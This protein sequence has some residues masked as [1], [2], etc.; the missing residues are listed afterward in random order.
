MERGQIV[1]RYRIKGISRRTKTTDLCSR[2]LTLAIN[3]WPHFIDIDLYMYIGYTE[4]TSKES[5]LMEK[6]LYII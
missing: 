3:H 2:I 1:I 4:I 6:I 5:K